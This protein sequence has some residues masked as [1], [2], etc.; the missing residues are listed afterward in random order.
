[1]PTLA[2]NT[3]RLKPPG[4]G[5]AGS[6]F[7]RRVAGRLDR[8]RHGGAR[9][10]FGQEAEDIILLGKLAAPVG[11]RG[12][13]VDVG[14]HHPTHF[15]NTFLFHRMGWRGV[16]IDATP[17]VE[18]LFRK[19]RPGDAFEEA[20]VG[21]G[22]TVEFVDFA[23]HAVSGVAGDTADARAA[24]HP[25]DLVGRRTVATRRLGDL[26]REHV[27][28]GT[29]VDFLTVDVEGHELAVLESNDWDAYRPRAVLAEVGDAPTLAD[30]L[31]SPVAAYP[32]RP[33]LR[34][35]RQDRRHRLLR[36][37]RPAPPH[38]QRLCDRR[39]SRGR[40]PL[41]TGDTAIRIE[42]LGKRY[43]IG[44]GQKTGMYRYKSLRDTLGNAVRRP[45]SL[46]GRRGPMTEANS[47]WA[48]DDVGFEVQAR[49]G[50]GHHR[51]QR[52]GQEHAAENPQ[53]HHQAHRRPRRTPRPGRTR[54]SMS[55]ERVVPFAKSLQ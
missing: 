53:P 33:G 38:A 55:H 16:N 11:R 12:F 19:A 13:Y 25:G 39:R 41:M 45:L 20:V 15:S 9:L 43:R 40:T 7:F 3:I 4:R 23:G 37:P 47:F 24:A 51:P 6:S 1:M 30:A 18:A 50:R 22:G 32:Q 35:L 44:V 26:L 5:R 42:G 36:P 14:A 34:R 29:P 2:S 27:P 48:L 21:D 52:R 8:L 49:R 10:A 17:G 46:L 31:A 28:A 54:N